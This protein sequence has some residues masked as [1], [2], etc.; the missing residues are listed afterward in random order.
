MTS[1]GLRLEL[2]LTQK[3]K[4]VYR[5]GMAHAFT[6][7]LN[8][9]YKGRFVTLRLKHPNDINP[10]PGLGNESYGWLRDTR[11]DLSDKIPDD[12]IQKRFIIFT[13]TIPAKMNYRT[14]QTLW[15]QLSSK[16]FCSDSRRAR[17]YKDEWRMGALRCYTPVGEVPADPV[18]YFKSQRLEELSDIALIVSMNPFGV[19]LVATTQS[20]ELQDWPDVED[21]EQ[22]KK[23][24][25]GEMISVKTKKQQIDGVYSYVINLDV[26]EEESSAVELESLGKLSLDPP[27]I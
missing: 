23:R 4:Y 24:V 2:F 12:H 13:N 11:I 20:L 7:V 19:Q 3:K 6:A 8:C 14:P 27:N 21:V 18:M 26:V 9:K 22:M 17:L 25:H 16:L 5:T 1:K 10:Q 15:V